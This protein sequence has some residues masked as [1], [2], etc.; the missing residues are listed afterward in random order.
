VQLILRLNFLVS[1]LKEA[2]L[3]GN[4]LLH[5]KLDDLLQNIP[6]LWHE[7]GEPFGCE[8]C[9]MN[10]QRMLFKGG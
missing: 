5:M 6:N 1:K 8:V 10:K 7:H 4:Q 3:L 2:I 9:A